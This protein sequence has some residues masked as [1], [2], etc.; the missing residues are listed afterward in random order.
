MKQVFFIVIFLFVMIL[1]S[2]AQLKGG[3]KGGL[4]VGDIIISNKAGYFDDVAFETRLSYHFGTYVQ[5]KFNNHFSWQ[6][7]MQFSN[8]GY[9]VET[10]DTKSTVS[11]NY[12][13]LPLLL[14][15]KPSPKLGLETGLEFGYLI[16]GDDLFNSFDMGIDIGVN[17][18]I[19]KKINTGIRYNFGL[20]FEM[21]IDANEIEG[22]IPKYQNSV[23]QVYVGFNLINE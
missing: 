11:L 22:G 19:S 8:K 7:E 21:N 12:L 3:I 16:S 6:I 5:N 10:G 20:P 13:N 1:T 23:F 4:N 14:I 9:Y 17:Y 2:T 18:E 15:Y